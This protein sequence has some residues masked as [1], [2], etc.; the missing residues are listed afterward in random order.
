MAGI[1]EG[2]M[3]SCYSG[4]KKIQDSAST[5]THGHFSVTSFSTSS[6]QGILKSML[7]LFFQNKLP[8]WVFETKKLLWYSD[9]LIHIPLNHRNSSY[10]WQIPFHWRNCHKPAFPATSCPSNSAL[11]FCIHTAGSPRAWSLE[12]VLESRC[13]IRM[14]QNVTG[15]AF[16]RWLLF[17]RGM[18]CVKDRKFCGEWKSYSCLKQVALSPSLVVLWKIEL[19]L[20]VSCLSE[21]VRTP[22]APWK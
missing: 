4:L 7:L 15:N 5:V 20:D 8:H 18:W 6:T 22:H 16:C 14:G 13:W 17:N 3:C 12:Q 10:L 2:R 19:Q 9:F 21:C 11:A 1:E